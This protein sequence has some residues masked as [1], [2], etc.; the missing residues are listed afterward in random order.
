MRA[1][2]NVMVYLRDPGGAV[3]P[4][5]VREGH[6]VFTNV[7]RTWLRD[8]FIWQTIDNTADVPFFEDR[9]AYFAYGTGSQPASVHVNDLVSQVGSDFP[10]QAGKATFPVSTTLRL[11]HVLGTGDLNGNILTESGLRVASTGSGVSSSVA[12]YK[13]FEPVLKTLGFEMVTI[14]E[15][16]F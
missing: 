2:A 6:N 9:L 7:G 8:L 13:T 11:E 14:W 16:K 15:L 10:L 5:S 12:F 4:G 1:G 3:V